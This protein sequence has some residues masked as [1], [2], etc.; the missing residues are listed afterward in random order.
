MV[1]L[2]SGALILAY[3]AAGLHF[4][5]FWRRTK[6]RLFL[7]FAIAFWLFALNQLASSVPIVTDDTSGYE[8]LLR[9]IGFV[10][11]LIAIADKNLSPPSG[12]RE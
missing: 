5:K 12:G 10:I 8:Y 9:V 3:A 7:H 4:L 11:I 2:L 6:D 1:Q